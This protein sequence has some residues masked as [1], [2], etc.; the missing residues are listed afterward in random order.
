MQQEG[1]FETFGEN[2]ERGENRSVREK[3]ETNLCVV[4]AYTEW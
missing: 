2:Q 4:L 1:G 3:R